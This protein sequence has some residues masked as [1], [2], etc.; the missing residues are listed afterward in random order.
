MKITK[1]FSG[2]TSEMINGRAQRTNS[3]CPLSG[4]ELNLRQSKGLNMMIDLACQFL[5]IEPTW[6]IRKI[7]KF[8]LLDEVLNNI[9]VQFS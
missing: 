9:L 1:D 2:V 6:S 3:H 4:T 7:M 8:H 5:K